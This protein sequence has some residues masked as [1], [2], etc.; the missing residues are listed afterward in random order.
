M[1]ESDVEREKHESGG[2]GKASRR[3]SPHPEKRSNKPGQKQTPKERGQG[4]GGVRGVPEDKRR[5]AG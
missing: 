4:K 2:P 1:A 5:P 3:E